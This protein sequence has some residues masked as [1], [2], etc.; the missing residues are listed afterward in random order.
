[1]IYSMIQQPKRILTGIKPTGDQIH[2]GNY[3]GAVKPLLDL[4][5]QYPDADIYCFVAIMHA[6]TTLHDGDAIKKNSINMVKLY[7]A[8]GL[9][10]QRFVI[11]NPAMISAHAEVTWVMSCITH[12]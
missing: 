11:Y 12:M 5:K 4:A 6:L 9:D 10:P 7:V 3:F 1:M 2:I 8:C